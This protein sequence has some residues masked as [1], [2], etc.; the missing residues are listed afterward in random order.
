MSDDKLLERQRR[1]VL[2]PS[3]GGMMHTIL[4]HNSAFTDHRWEAVSV[5]VG[6]TLVLRHNYLR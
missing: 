3:P 6:D 4:I 5:A 1:R 2:I